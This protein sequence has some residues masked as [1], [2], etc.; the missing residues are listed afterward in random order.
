MLSDQG[1]VKARKRRG[2]AG[3][4]QG[5]P[6][7]GPDQNRAR[8]IGLFGPAMK[9]ATDYQL[10]T[11]KDAGNTSLLERP[12]H[13]FSI[14]RQQRYQ[15]N[16]TFFPLAATEPRRSLRSPSRRTDPTRSAVWW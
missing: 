15:I 7:F 11:I 12:A 14:K 16:P 5:E 13:S 9:G 6:D 2:H 8:L 4:K 10:R 3:P 1:V